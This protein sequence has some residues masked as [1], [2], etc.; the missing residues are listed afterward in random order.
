[1]LNLRTEPAFGDNVGRYKLLGELARGGMGIVYVAAAQGPAGFSKLV[2]LKELRPDFVEDREFLTMFLDE[3]R[4]AARLNHPNIVLTSDV[5][6]QDGRHFIAMEYLEGRSLHQVTRRFSQKGGFP[7]RMSI[8]ILR[9]VLSALDYAHSLTDQNGAQLG[10]VH[11]DVS[12]HNVFV[13]FGGATKVIDF[14][15]AKARDSSLETKT[16]VLKGRVNY[17]APEQLTH[18]AERRS[19]LFSVGAILFEVVTGRRLWQGLG[20]VEVLGRLARGEIPSLAAISHEAPAPLLQIC[21]IAL[22]AKPEDRF[23]SAGEMRDALDEYLWQSGGA[24][25]ISEIGALISKEFRAEREKLRE[26]ID[27]SLARLKTGQSGRMEALALPEPREPTQSHYAVRSAAEPHVPSLRRGIVAEMLPDYV[28]RHWRP[29]SSALAAIAVVSTVGAIRLHRAPP[30]PVEGELPRV[31]APAPPSPTV[32]QLAAAPAPAPA[33]PQLPAPSTPEMVTLSI[34]VSPAGAQ[35]S[36][37]GEAVPSNPF[38]GRYAKDPAMHLVRAV[39]SGYAP[40]ERLVSFADNVFVDLALTPRPS[41][42]PP[43]R[44]REPSRRIELPRPVVVVPAPR[45]IATPA[46]PPP[47]A[48]PPPAPPSHASDIAARPEPRRRAI[49][50]N[51]PYG[52]EK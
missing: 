2:A 31:A 30:P 46:P 50:S 44:E 1:M 35:L 29:I 47:A 14:G 33:T 28:L 43:R 24:P 45:P 52:D 38:V 16:G 10:F 39:A 5:S 4:M 37:D 51:N 18:R 3:A 12:P 15:I 49:D 32:T 23:A 36:V 42:P 19:D 27:A 40:K 34:S 41:A 11:R 26:F 13:T 21:Q 25:T 7:Q 17:M 48:A 6:E 8:A 20:E 9:D 22:R